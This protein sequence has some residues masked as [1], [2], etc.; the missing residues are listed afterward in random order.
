MPDTQYSPKA[1][2]K[3]LARTYNTPSYDD[4]YDAVSDYRRVQRAAANHP[5]MGSSALS[6]IVEL[7][8]S[9]I[10]GWVDD[11]ADS[12]P[13]AV[14]GISVAQNKGWLDPTGDTAVALAAI[15]GHLFGAGPQKHSVNNIA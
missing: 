11:D 1:I 12:M 15:V 9:R 14:R 6:N 5:N 13:D 10:R 3:R 2:E 4:P 7:P 8:R